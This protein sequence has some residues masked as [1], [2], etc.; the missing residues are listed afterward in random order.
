MSEGSFGLI[1]PPSNPTLEVEIRELLGASPHLY[2]SRL[3]F[4]EHPD[5]DRRHSI[6][7]EACLDTALR[8]GTLPLLGI[9]VGCTGSFYC[10]GPHEDWRRCQEISGRLG[11]P[12]LTASLASLTLIKSLGFTRIQLEM[13]YPDWLITQ[14]VDYFLAAGL[15]VVATHSLLRSIGV[16]H[17]YEIEEADLKVVL[18]KLQVEPNTL[19]FLSGTGLFSL[20]AHQEVVQKAEVPLL[21]A[22]LSIANWLLGR[23]Q[24]PGRGSVMLRQLMARLEGWAPAI[25]DHGPD[26]MFNPW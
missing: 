8:F 15:E 18:Q 19:V 17:P 10:L 7:Q 24:P 12:Y 26:L 14:A 16:N 20:E 9:I 23:L 2:T 13:P 5:L 4:C 21:S 25:S 1:V 11:M 3:P 6:Y 22:N